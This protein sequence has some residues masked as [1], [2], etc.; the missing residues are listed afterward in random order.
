MVFFSSLV[1]PHDSGRHRGGLSIIINIYIFFFHSPW[2]HESPSRTTT[3]R[4]PRL[5]TRDQRDA[6]AEGSARRKPSPSK[7]RIL[8]VFFGFRTRRHIDNNYLPVFLFFVTVVFV[9]DNSSAIVTQRRQ[10]EHCLR[11]NVRRFFPT[12][13]ERV[14]EISL[15]I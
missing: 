1:I 15:T 2:K 12:R 11:T 8:T 3:V 13:H 9:F 4:C 10:Q 5:P 6:T 7:E 14:R